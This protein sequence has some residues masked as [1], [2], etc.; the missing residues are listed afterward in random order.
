MKQEKFGWLFG[1]LLLWGHVN[2]FAQQAPLPDSTTVPPAVSSATGLI[3]Q[4]VQG[5]LPAT[6]VETSTLRFDPNIKVSG[7]QYFH[8]IGTTGS[9]R[10]NT[11]RAK[12]FQDEALQKAR[13]QK[14]LKEEAT[15]SQPIRLT[16]ESKLVPN[17]TPPPTGVPDNQSLR[18]SPNAANVP[19]DDPNAYVK[20]PGSGGG[21]VGRIKSKKAN[22]SSEVSDPNLVSVPAPAYESPSP[23][24]V[25]TPPP[26]TP[27][28]M[29]APPLPPAMPPSDVPEFDTAAFNMPQPK[30]KLFAKLFAPKA[31]PSHDP[32][33]A[34]VEEPSVIAKPVPQ[35]EIA[36]PPPPPEPP[37]PR[38][39]FRP[40]SDARRANEYS[41]VK[42]Q[43]I[44]AMVD[45]E[46]LKLSEG[47]RVKVIRTG[48]ERSLILLYDNRQA[49]IANSALV[50]SE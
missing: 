36:V 12:Q 32:D 45:G 17:E 19:P 7:D 20:M 21:L 46:P 31:P 18:D 5:T 27:T 8:Q 40:S 11:D 22:S 26:A 16:Y 25:T 2:G 39:V 33:F 37:K 38:S 6:T 23:E 41:M 47:T 13:L 10:V 34:A 35:M 1:I 42:G 49:T 48:T 50:P 4:P 44:F 15:T 3:T 28:P 30:K 14:R 24:L 9:Y 43:E 29:P